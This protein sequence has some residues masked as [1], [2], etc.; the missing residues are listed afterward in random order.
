MVTKNKACP[1]TLGKRHVNNSIALALLKEAWIG[2]LQQLPIE[3]PGTLA[4]SA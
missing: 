4:A 1:S 3:I 2:T